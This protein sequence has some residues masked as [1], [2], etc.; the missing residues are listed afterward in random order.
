MR[1]VIAVIPAKKTFCENKE[2]LTKHRDFYLKGAKKIH[3]F[4]VRGVIVPPLPRL[5][6]VRGVIAVISA[7]MTFCRIDYFRNTK[8]ER[9]KKPE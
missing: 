6:R 9:F 8:I 4:R 1:G 2:K 3:K 7:K 5:I